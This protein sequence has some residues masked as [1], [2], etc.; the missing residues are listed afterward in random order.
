L[1]APDLKIL[2]LIQKWE[3]GIGIYKKIY[4]MSTDSGM[5]S[6]DMPEYHQ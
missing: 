6:W 5:I 3:Y 2:L 4:Y 1:K